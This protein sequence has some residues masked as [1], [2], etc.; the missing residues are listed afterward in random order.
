MIESTSLARFQRRLVKPG[1]RL[2]K[3]GDSC[4]KQK[5]RRLPE[6]RM[7][8]AGLRHGGWVYA[9][10]GVGSLKWILRSRPFIGNGGKHK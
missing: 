4:A 9:E 10:S 7:Q 6:E 5:R 3:E 2:A 1:G 8:L